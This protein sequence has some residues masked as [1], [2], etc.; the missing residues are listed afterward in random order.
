MAPCGVQRDRGL[1]AASNAGAD[2]VV[3]LMASTSAQM[4][5]PPI[6]SS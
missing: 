6:V 2:M 3:I 5:K 4:P 1:Y